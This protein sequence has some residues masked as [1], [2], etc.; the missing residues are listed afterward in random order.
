MAVHGSKN[1]WSKTVEANCHVTITACVSASG[2][3]VPPL[4]LVPGKRLNRDVMDAAT[5]VPGSAVTVAPKGFMNSSIFLKWLEHFEDS[6]PLRVKRP[7]ILV[8][9]GLGSHHS[10]EIVVKAIELKIILVLLPANATHLVQ[11]LDISVFK[12]FK[13]CLKAT[14]D[15][16]MLENSVTSFQKKDA[17]A[18]SSS[19]WNEAIVSKPQNIVSGFKASGLWPPSLV[20]MKKRWTLSHDGGV[21]AKKLD[22]EP[23][24]C[25]REEIRTEI[26]SLPPPIDRTPKRRKALDVN[27]RL[28]TREQLHEYDD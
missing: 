2:Y 6:V 20:E 25:T 26:L 3:V 21:D 24:I 9:D 10:D 22:I 8:Y 11:P 18:I 14:M 1:V 19:A 15:K 28:L 27:N 16:F 5:E 12:P 4:Y 23:W 7:L 13:T 17:I